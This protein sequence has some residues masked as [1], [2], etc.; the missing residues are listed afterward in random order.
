METIPRIVHIDRYALIPKS[1]DAIEISKVNIIF[2]EKNLFLSRFLRT[3]NTFMLEELNRVKLALS[4]ND[5]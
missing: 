4:T 1:V 3:S 2:W 5:H